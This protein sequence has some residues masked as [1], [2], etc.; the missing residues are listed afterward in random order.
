MTMVFDVDGIADDDGGIAVRFGLSVLL[1]RQRSRGLC[2]CFGFMFWFMATLCCYVVSVI[3]CCAR[4]YGNEK[5][6]QGCLVFLWILFVSYA[7]FI[8]NSKITKYDSITRRAKNKRFV[9]QYGDYCTSK[10]GRSCLA[11]IS[12]PWQSRKDEI[13][14]VCAKALAT[15]TFLY[16]HTF[17]ILGAPNFK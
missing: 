4:Q 12:N 2:R 7:F 10:G 6:E 3:F 8:L 13:Q 15:Y 5:D 16:G 11:K 17:I 9:L 14:I 1:G